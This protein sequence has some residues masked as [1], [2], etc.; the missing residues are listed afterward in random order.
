MKNIGYWDKKYEYI[1]RSNIKHDDWLDTFDNIITKCRTDI[2][3]LGCGDG[4]NTLALLEKCKQVIPCDASVNA[5]SNIIRNF[6]EIEQANCYN[7]MYGL[8]YTDCTFDMV[9][10]DQSLQYFTDNFTK[11]T[12]LS[13]KR[14]IKE[15]GTLLFRVNSINDKNYKKDKIEEIEEHFYLNKDGLTIRYFSLD[16]IKKYF[17]NGTIEYLEETTLKEND[18]QKTL[19]K[20]CIR[21]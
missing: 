5:I 12:L 16:D 11:K 10:A 7:F 18:K 21:Y 2:L 1:M 6:P 13:I 3:D 14:V 15:N 4:K 17:G 8:P 19:W 20:G 9:V